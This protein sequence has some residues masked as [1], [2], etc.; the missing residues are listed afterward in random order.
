LIA[1]GDLRTL[2]NGLDH[3]EGVALGPDQMLYAGGEAGQ[4]YRIDPS[5]GAFEQVAD[6]GGFVLGL[7][8]DGQGRIYVCD[9]ARAA[10]LR[11]DPDTT[12]VDVY[13]ESA[14]EAPLICPNW[15]AFAPNGD[16][17][18]SDSG[19]EILAVREGRLLR[20]PPGGGP[21]E[22]AMLPP[23][24]FPNGLAVAEDGTVYLLESFTPKLSSYRGA[25]LTTIAEFPGVVPDGVALCRDGSFIVAC[26]YPY[27]LLQVTQSGAVTTLLD[28]ETGIHCPMPTNVAFFGEG[29]RELAIAS[30][31]G[32][33]ITALDPGCEGAALSYPSFDLS[34]A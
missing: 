8:L 1:T 21:A 19:R 11:I 27:R 15:L 9:S 30:L 12:R 16:L 10:I 5:A 2:V 34:A 7:C 4:V 24:H 31:G 25:G 22:V 3:P 23:L 17:W 18:F 28:D 6:T 14:G 29:L 26:Y 20:V 33:A 13:C 32:T